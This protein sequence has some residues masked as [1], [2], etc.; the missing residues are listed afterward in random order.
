MIS[1]RTPYQAF[2]YGRCLGFHP[3][4][5]REGG[6]VL[7]LFGIPLSLGIEAKAIAKTPIIM[8]II[9]ISKLLSSFLR[10][11]DRDLS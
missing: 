9:V 8:R 5:F 2:L 7:V 11:K 3:S 4:P 1:Q 6:D 10:C